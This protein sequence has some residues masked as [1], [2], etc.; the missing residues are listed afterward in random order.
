MAAWMWAGSVANYPMLQYLAR[1]KYIYWSTPKLRGEIELGDVA[2]IW[3]HKK[4]SDLPPGVIAIG[5]VIELP[6]LKEEIRHPE[7]LEENRWHVPP[8]SDWK[9]VFKLLTFVGLLLTECWRRMRWFVRS[10]ILTF[11]GTRVA[12]YFVSQTS[13]TNS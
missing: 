5:E 8:A 12:P 13:S 4:G 1:H 6:K 3:R 7:Y 2:Y 10:L 9:T 11:S